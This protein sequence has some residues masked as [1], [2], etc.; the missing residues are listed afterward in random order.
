M[1]KVVAAVS[2]L[3]ICLLFPY[4]SPGNLPGPADL[5]ELPRIAMPRATLAIPTENFQA[6]LQGLQISP[7]TQKIIYSFLGQYK[8]RLLTGETLV[9]GASDALYVGYSNGIGS[10]CGQVIKFAD[11]TD[12]TTRQELYRVA[13]TIQQNYAMLAGR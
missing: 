12:S 7:N 5:P 10:V 3:G 1:Y 13:L 4:L 11:F 6:L 9:S 8:D 2:G